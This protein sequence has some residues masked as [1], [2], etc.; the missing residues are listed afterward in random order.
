M[1]AATRNIACAKD[2]SEARDNTADPQA[3]QSQRSGVR[4]MISS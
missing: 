1:R 3:L 2:R 4:R